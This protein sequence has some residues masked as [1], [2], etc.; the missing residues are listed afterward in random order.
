M[1]KDIALGIV[2]GGAVGATLGRTFSDVQSRIGALQR[3]SNQARMWQSAIGETQRLQREFR[4]LHLAGDKAA[5]GIRK[6]IETHVAVLRKAG[7]EVGQLDRHY[8]Q[9][10]RTV[11]GLELKAAGRASIQSG[12]EQGRNTVGDAVKLT[13]AVAAPTVIAANYEAIVRDIAIKAGVART[14]KEASMSRHIID[15]SRASGMGRNEVAGSV[16]EMVGAGMDLDRALSFAP[17][18]A[19][20]SVGQGATP[21]DTAKMIK[22]LEQ[23]ANI[24][25]PAQMQQALEAVAYLGKEGSFE[26]SDMARWFPE[27]LAEMQ[28][29]GIVG[30]DSV[31]QLGAMLQV[32]MKTAGSSD[33][34]ANNLK[35]WLS[36]LGSGETRKNYADA[37][38]DYD[39]SMQ[40]AIDQGYSTVEASFAL[41]QAYIQKTDPQKAAQ[42][43]AA[44]EQLSKV[45]DPKKAEEMKAAFEAAM[46]TGDLFADMQVK[47]ALTAYMQ[48]GELYRKLKR[49]AAQANGEIE[50]DLADRRA[51]S[52][53]MWA[54]VGQAWDGAMLSLGDAIRPVTDAAGALAKGLGD[55]LAQLTTAAPLATAALVGVAGAMIGV[56]AAMTVWKLGKGVFDI[57]RGGL[58]TRGRKIPGAAGKAAGVVDDLIGVATG[59][60][61]GAQP[62]FVTNWPA[63]GGLLDLPGDLGGKGGA[64]KAGKLGRFGRWGARLGK[65][66]PYVGKLGGALAIA[67]AGYQVYDTYRNA[68][69]RDE[70]AEGYGGAVGML[71][72]GLA[73]AT[74]GALAG[75]W[76][77]PI[78]VAIGGVLGGA[79]GAYVGDKAIGAAA[80]WAFGDKKPANGPIATARPDLTVAAA[81]ILR[82]GQEAARLKELLPPPAKPVA[83]AV[84]QSVS[85]APTLSVVVKGD[86]KDPKKLAGE[87]MPHIQQMFAAFQAQQGR[88]VMFDPAHV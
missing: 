61:V 77:G 54:E 41:A 1:S 80:K 79:I 15:T 57:A 43:A 19:K 34:A 38:I 51:T 12:I 25:D 75:A 21:A 72:G 16:N 28:K 39:K 23:N 78:G 4:A 20:F 13:A 11:R 2:I 36:K 45:S 8:Q 58:L 10:G 50:R 70:K 53:Q 71:A 17:L 46:K 69:T 48:N 85:F 22:A 62:V 44:G 24:T 6:K 49:D 29:A 73:G 37:G 55:G 32:Q 27:L 7:F 56:R 26:A 9:L 64:G 14:G 65:V 86:V 88:S 81:P 59:A 87:L 67:G 40:E 31:N 66:M 68:K 74:L 52:K 63:G 42:L 33:Q 30:L 47:A 84:A 82:P 18:V 76:G 35:N 83:P 5:D 3:Q 60:G